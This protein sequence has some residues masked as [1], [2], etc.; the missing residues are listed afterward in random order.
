MASQVFFGSNLESK[1]WDA[2]ALVHKRLWRVHGRG[3]IWGFLMSS[4]DLKRPCRPCTAG[5]YQSWEF[6]F[7]S[8]VD[9]V[10][11]LAVTDSGAKQGRVARNSRPT[12]EQFWSRNRKVGAYSTL[13]WWRHC[14]CRS[15]SAQQATIEYKCLLIYISKSYCTYMLPWNFIFPHQQF[16]YSIS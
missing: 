11:N 2:I 8:E 9:R 6:G 16:L 1:S 12:L 4:I 15:T 3:R 5:Q 14:Q 7:C 10:L 13:A